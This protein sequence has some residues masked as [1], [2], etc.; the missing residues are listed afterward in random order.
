MYYVLSKNIIESE[1]IS[2]LPKRKR[3]FKSQYPLSETGNHTKG[4]N[5]IYYLLKAYLALISFTTKLFSGIVVVGV[6][7]GFRY[8]LKSLPRC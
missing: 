7:K 6:R 3:G 5:G 2:Y 4:F 8:L 1:I